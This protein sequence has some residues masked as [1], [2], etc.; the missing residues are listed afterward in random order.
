MSPCPISAPFGWLGISENVWLVDGIQAVCFPP[1]PASNKPNGMTLRKRKAREIS[2]D[3]GD[4]AVPLPDRTR[5]KRV[6]TATAAKPSNG[7]ACA[8]PP[9][10]QSARLATS[11]S[12]PQVGNARLPN[13]TAN[14]TP[15]TTGSSGDAKS[16][17]AKMEQISES[18]LV[19]GAE[20]GLLFQ[21]HPTVPSFRP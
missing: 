6:R 2:K 14:A 7:E 20:S 19:D 16:K 5:V 13:V 8:T 1:R 9:L 3:E 10:R 21:S 4:A 17:E 18:S 11:G 15:T 12:T